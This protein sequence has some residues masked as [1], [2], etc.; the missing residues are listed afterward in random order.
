MIYGNYSRST[1]LYIGETAES[2]YEASEITGI[3]VEFLSEFKSKGCPAFRGSRVHLQ[4]EYDWA[5]LYDR[6]AI[7]IAMMNGTKMKPSAEALL[8]GVLSCMSSIATGIGRLQNLGLE[9]MLTTGVEK[10]R[11]LVSECFEVLREK[12]GEELCAPISFFLDEK[13][14]RFLAKT[15]ELERVIAETGICDIKNDAP[16]SRK[17]EDFERW[18]AENRNDEKEVY[19]PRLRVD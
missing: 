10:D 15:S 17:I 4:W 14:Y 11:H 18:Y 1:K 19:C 13:V 8:A 7:E 3:P 2:L 12:M 6:S 9:L 5:Y 16:M